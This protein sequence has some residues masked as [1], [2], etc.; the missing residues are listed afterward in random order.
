MSEKTETNRYNDPSTGRFMKGNPG[1][2]KGTRHMSTLLRE[3][4]E[5]ELESGESYGNLITKRVIKSALEGQ[6][7]AMRLVYE[8]LDGKPLQNIDVNAK[9]ESVNPE[10][11]EEIQE[12]LKDI[13]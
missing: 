12:A 3:A 1:K 10:R 11:A 7:W 5:K 8:Y 4:I 2:P 13:I 6:S 9:I